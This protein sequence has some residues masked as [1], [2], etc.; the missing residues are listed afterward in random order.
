MLRIFAIAAV[1]LFQVPSGFACKCDRQ[2][3]DIG[4]AYQK[5]DLI[6]LGQCLRAEF[7]EQK[8]SNQTPFVQ[9][10]F[11]VK[12]VWKGHPD[13]ETIL[14]KTG[15]GGGDCG[16]AFRPGFS[17]IVYGYADANF[18]HTDTCTRTLP[19]GF[20]PHLSQN[21]KDEIKSLDFERS[22]Q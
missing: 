9:Y 14:V 1:M 21:A 12:K 6:F 22:R 5:A 18:L 19:A 8:G 17:Y 16:W 4:L 11:L 2:G 15:L 7:V 20:Y 10:T 13:T 3:P